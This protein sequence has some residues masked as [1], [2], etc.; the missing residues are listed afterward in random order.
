MAR[1]SI[2]LLGVA[3]AALMAPASGARLG[4]FPGLS[5]FMLG[6]EDEGVVLEPT[7]LAFSRSRVAMDA[8][9]MRANLQQ[10]AAKAGEVVREIMPA[11]VPDMSRRSL[12]QTDY[13]GSG[14]RPSPRGG[15]KPR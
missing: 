5:S 11:A 13:V 7:D 15:F 12:M 1:L 2:F 8:A 4:L 10:L 6:S 3:L 9:N 14:E